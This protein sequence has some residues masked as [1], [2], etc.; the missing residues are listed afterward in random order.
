M[1]CCIYRVGALWKTYEDM[2]VFLAD[3][4]TKFKDVKL[5]SS[6]TMQKTKC[7]RYSLTLILLCIRCTTIIWDTKMARKMESISLCDPSKTGCSVPVVYMLNLESNLT[8]MYPFAFF[9]FKG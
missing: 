7:E 6:I 9:I 5:V 8:Y 2:T 4:Y 3:A 1:Y